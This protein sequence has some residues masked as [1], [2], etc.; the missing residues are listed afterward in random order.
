MEARDFFGNDGKISAFKR[1][2]LSLEVLKKGGFEN[3][4]EKFFN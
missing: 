2:I 1:H 4:K 3:E